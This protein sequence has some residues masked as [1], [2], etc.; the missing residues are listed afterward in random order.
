MTALRLTY[1]TAGQM[2]KQTLKPRDLIPIRRNESRKVKTNVLNKWS[3]KVEIPKI[4]V[5]ERRDSTVA[6]F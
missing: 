5:H 4:E 1:A 6:A 3:R 2:R